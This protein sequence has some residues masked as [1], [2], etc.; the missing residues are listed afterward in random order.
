MNEL[1]P[2][3]AGVVFAYGLL[4]WGPRDTRTRVVA[5]VV[6]AVVMGVVAA[7]VSGEI[8]ESWLF[9]VVDTVGTMIAIAVSA[10]VMLKIGWPEQRR[11]A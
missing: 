11:S 4:Q 2:I 7:T 1:L 10:L 5:S 9:V 3:A 8:A 6:F